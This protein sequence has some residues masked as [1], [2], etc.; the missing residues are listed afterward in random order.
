MIYLR[1]TG[2]GPILFQNERPLAVCNP[3][4]LKLSR[5]LV[6]C[7]VELYRS[8]ASFLKIMIRLLYS[9]ISFLYVIYLLF[10]DVVLHI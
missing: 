2:M 1:C 9:P 8:L 5:M 3:T 7:H 4:E 10:C 6:Y